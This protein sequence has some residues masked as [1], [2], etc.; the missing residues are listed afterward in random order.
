MPVLTELL[1]IARPDQSA[2]PMDAYVAR[3]DGA[4]SY[5]GVLVIHEIFGLNDNIKDITR[6]FAEAGYVALAIDLFSNTNRPLCMLRVFSGIFLRP[7]RNGT[8][9]EVQAALSALQRQ[10]T[11]DSSR[12]GAIGFCMGGSYALQ[13]ACVDGNLQA[14]SIFYGQNPRPLEAVARACPIVGSYPQRDTTAGAARKLAQALDAY[15]V[16]HDI[17][18]YPRTLHSF[19]NDHLPAY[20]AEA[21]ADAWARTLTFF[22]KHLTVDTG[23]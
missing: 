2:R 17:R 1:S 14:A 11:V 5:P 3:P 21:A 15:A 12:L 4:G 7:L 19:F 6:R 16:P 10:P 9:T 23:L 13:L 20:D 22:D 8:L 18:I